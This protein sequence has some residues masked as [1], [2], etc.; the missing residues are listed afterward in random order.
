MIRFRLLLIAIGL[1]LLLLFAAFAV[2]VVIAVANQNAAAIF[3]LLYSGLLLIAA[4]IPYA[5]YVFFLDR[6]GTRAL[7]LEQLGARSS[8][9]RAHRL[10]LKRFGRTL[11]VWL[12]SLAVGLVVGILFAIAFGIVVIPFAIVAGVLLATGSAVFWP[13]VVLFVI[14]V[15]PIA[16]VVGGFLASVSSTYW[17]LAFRRLDLDY[18]APIT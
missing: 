16:L 4:A 17:T 5:L 1:P 11:V 8:I 2:A 6:L 12:L 10:L 18:R 13:L 14:I 3:P 7:V 9:A 15:A